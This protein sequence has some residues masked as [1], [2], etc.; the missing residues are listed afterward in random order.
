MGPAELGRRCGVRKVETVLIGVSLAAV[1]LVWSGPLGGDTVTLAPQASFEHPAVLVQR[2]ET[3]PDPYIRWDPT[4]HVY[5]LFSTQTIWGNVPE[6]VSKSETGPWTFVRD[7]LPIRPAWA[8]PGFDMWAPEIQDVNGTWTMWG[9]TRIAQF[10]DIN[11]LYRATSR[12]EAG[13]YNLDPRTQ[14]HDF[15]MDGDIDPSMTED[16]GTWYLIYKINGNTFG[17]P[18]E[19]I[20]EKIGPTGLPIGPEHLLLESGLSWE[21]GMVEAPRMIQNQSNGRWW[22]VFSTGS[23]SNLDP[24]YEIEAV[25][26]HSITGPCYIDQV[27]A[28]VATNV[29]GHGPGEESLSTDQY[30]QTWMP[31]NPE[32]PF[33]DSALRPLAQVKLDFNLQGEPYVVTP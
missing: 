29:Q 5:L 28:L 4:R 9:S 19:A 14:C 24:S 18:T 12:A 13:P 17:K 23:F 26:C 31:Y 16:D 3:F 21:A 15:T 11:C 20:A 33:R 22:L 32:G 27:V 8:W 7:A 25:P 6:Y 1:L 30:G 10:P 2:T